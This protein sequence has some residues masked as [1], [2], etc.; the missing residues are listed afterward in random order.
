[1]AAAPLRDGS[2]LRDTVTASCQLAISG[3]AGHRAGN[4]PDSESACGMRACGEKQKRVLRT[5]VL[6]SMPPATSRPPRSSSR[7]SD[8]LRAHE[9]S[10]LPT[11]KAS[12]S[13]ASKAPTDRRHQSEHQQFT[14]RCL[15]RNPE[16]LKAL[17]RR[18]A[19]VG[20][21]NAAQH[22]GNYGL[23][24]RY[25][26]ADVRGIGGGM[27]HAGFA[28]RF[29]HQHLVAGPEPTRGSWTEVS[30]GARAQRRRIPHTHGPPHRRR[31]GKGLTTRRPD[32]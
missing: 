16:A 21:R 26:G 13:H 5:A 27:L 9:W 28:R 25:M 2:W 20:D 11:C 7:Q 23:V 3:L 19:W 29:P 1:V 15:A 22:P 10:Y 4:L 17:L 8:D 32:R 18:F 6:A 24:Q 14:S 12:A 30:P 31:P